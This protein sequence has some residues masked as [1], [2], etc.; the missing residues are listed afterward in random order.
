MIKKQHVPYLVSLP[1]V[2]VIFI[3]LLPI[4]DFQLKFFL[5]S[6]SIALVGYLIPLM[7]GAMFLSGRLKSEV[8]EWDWRVM[9]LLMAWIPSVIL[10]N[11]MAVVTVVALVGDVDDYI[12][13]LATLL[14]GNYLFVVTIALWAV[15]LADRVR[16]RLIK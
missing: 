1:A 7:S 14:L 5:L 15:L 3:G 2:V 9:I 4:G 6:A 11:I 12:V 13:H 10:A 16:D 8:F